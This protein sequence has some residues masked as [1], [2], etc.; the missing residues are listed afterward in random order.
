VTIFINV[1]SSLFIS[2]RGSREKMEYDS[3]ILG[4][5][6]FVAEIVREAEKKVRRYAL[7]KEFR[8]K[9]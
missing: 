3:R 2:L 6:D 7:E 9:N 4:D 8:N 1:P 5:G